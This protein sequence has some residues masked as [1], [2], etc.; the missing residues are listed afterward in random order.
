MP[1]RLAINSLLFS[2][3][4]KYLLTAG[5]PPPLLESTPFTTNLGDD[6]VVR[7]WN[8]DTFECQQTLTNDNWGQVTGLIWIYHTLPS[9]EIVTSLSVGSARGYATLYPLDDRGTKVR[10]SFVF[11]L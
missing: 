8:T 1:S 7:V 4:A 2:E 3:D 10:T 5:T 6:E 9:K 11:D